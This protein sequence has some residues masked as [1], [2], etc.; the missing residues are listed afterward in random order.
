MPQSRADVLTLLS[1]TEEMT[2]HFADRP[3]ITMSMGPLGVISRVSG[4]SFGS[5]ATFGSAGHARAPGQLDVEALDTVL[6]I[7]DEVVPC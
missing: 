3:V 2:A 1:A 5:A 4:Q 6:S 7:L